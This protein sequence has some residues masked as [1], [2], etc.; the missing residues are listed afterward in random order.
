[1]AS[2]QANARAD[3]PVALSMYPNPPDASVSLEDFEAYAVDRLKVMSAVEAANMKGSKHQELDAV[4][5]RAMEGT[6]LK[7]RNAQEVKEDNIS[8]WVLRLAF[9]A[10]EDL[11]RRFIAFEMLVFKYRFKVMRTSEVQQF[12]VENKLGYRPIPDE[13]KKRH[14]AGYGYL[15]FCFLL[16]KDNYYYYPHIGIAL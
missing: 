14:A 6:H 11:R 12:I 9:C 1:M 15:D 16:G 7:C 2:L 10:N 13:E 3:A 4:L 5:E 8:H